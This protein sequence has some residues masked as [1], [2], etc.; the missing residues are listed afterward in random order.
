MFAD[1]TD[2]QT[3][4]AARLADAASNRRSAMHMP[5]VG[6]AD[7]DVR[8]MVLRAF[9]A[10]LWE[11][12][13]NTDARSSKVA[14]IGSGAP[15]G[16]AFYDPA[17]KVQIRARGVGRVETSGAQVDAA[18]AKADNFA[19]RCYLAQS[20]PG[21]AMAAPGSGLPPEVEGIKPSDEQLLPARA[22]FA[23]LLVALHHV[24]WLYLAHDGHRRAQFDLRG[25][26]VEG[27]WVVP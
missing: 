19:R 21:G 12:R 11:C 22:N 24:D 18:W 14:A 6:T 7:A 23:I 17:A 5:M 15:V 1:L 16:L 26:A 8:M 27:R 25:G 10:Q 4:I 20:A 13:L 2:V 9:D 3:D